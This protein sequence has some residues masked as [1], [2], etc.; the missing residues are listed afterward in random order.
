[1]ILQWRE[2]SVFPEP[3][4]RCGKDFGNYRDI[5]NIIRLIRRVHRMALGAVDLQ[6]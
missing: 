3:D 2:K 1:M 6:F 5:D 4:A